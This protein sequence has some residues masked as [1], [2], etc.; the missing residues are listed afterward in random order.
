MNRE[1]AVPPMLQGIPPMTRRALQ[2]IAYVAGIA[3][4]FVAGCLALTLAAL[5]GPDTTETP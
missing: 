5:C 4:T 1:L 3:A 2:P